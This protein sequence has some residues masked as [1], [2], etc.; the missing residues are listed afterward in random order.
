MSDIV[1]EEGFIYESNVPYHLY[2]SDALI[3]ENSHALMGLTIRD[4]GAAGDEDN[5]PTILT[6]LSLSLTNG[7]FI[8]R[9]GLFDGTT[10][11]AE[12]G[13]SS[14][15]TFSGLT[16]TVNDNSSKNVTMRVSYN[17]SVDDNAQIVGIVSLTKI[18]KQTKKPNLQKSP[19][20]F[21]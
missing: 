3:S 16:I 8:R 2:Q 17:A 11:I 19:I 10:K 6:S 5:L 1:E 21:C 9:V 13:G 12:T 15:V 18:Y 20:K 14:T 4:G 7:E